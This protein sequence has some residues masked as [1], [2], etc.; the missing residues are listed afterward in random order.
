MSAGI[1]NG[2]AIV[3]SPFQGGGMGCGAASGGKVRTAREGQSPGCKDGPAPDMAASFA[4]VNNERIR[5]LTL[6]AM[7]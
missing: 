1:G 4:M 6:P 5:A 3:G 7:R 2:L